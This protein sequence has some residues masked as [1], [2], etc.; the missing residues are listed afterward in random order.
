MNLRHMMAATAL[1]LATAGAF[2]QAKQQFVPVLSYRTG[3]YAPNGAPWANGYVDYL[4]IVNARGGVNGVQLAHLALQERPELKVLLTSG[5]V[6]DEAASWANEFPMI[7]KPYLGPALAAKVRAVLDA[8]VPA[9][10]P[11]KAQRG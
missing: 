3:A 6:G 1:G 9:K 8:E 7:D 2:A 4:K 10:A 11:A 5:Y